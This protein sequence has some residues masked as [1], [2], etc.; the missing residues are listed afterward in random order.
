MSVYVAVELQRKVRKQ[1]KH[2]C[3]YCR[4]TESLTATTFEFE[5][6]VGKSLGG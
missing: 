2:C 1:F 6:I 3:A 5:H 4:T